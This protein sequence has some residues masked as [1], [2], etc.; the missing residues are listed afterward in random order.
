[1]SQ[2]RIYDRFVP[3]EE[4][5]TSGN[6]VSQMSMN[7]Q[8]LRYHRPFIA[9]GGPNDG[10]AVVV[11]NELGRDGRPKWT[12]EKG[13]KKPILRQ[14]RVADLFL[15][16]DRNVPMWALNA[17]SFRRDD[18]IEVDKEVQTSY[19]QRLKL[20]QILQQ[21]VSVGGFN[22]W[23][24]MSY[25]YDAMSDAHEAIVDMDGLSDGRSDSP[26]FIPRSVPLPFTHS[27][28]WYSDRVLAASRANGGQGL[29]LYSS[30][31]AARRVAEK[32]EDTAIGITTGLTWGTRANYFPHDLT[33]TVFG[34]TNYTNRNVKTNFTTPTSTN[35]PTSYNEFLAAFNTLY[36]DY[37]Y[38]PFAIFH[39]TDWSTYMNSPFST[40]GG[41]HPSETLRTMLLKHPDVSSIERLDRLTS[42]F[43]VLI[44][45][46]DKK[47]IRFINGMD[48]TTWQW[49]DLG[50]LRKNFKVGA[51]QATLPLSD[52]SG[53]CGYLHG[54]TA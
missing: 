14:Q 41:N 1:M 52:Y 12:M 19:R 28:F 21:K 17:T 6:V 5:N 31:Q 45:S 7:Q 15:N 44:V 4:S 20:V 29:D 43:T 23:G 24:K 40:S 37:V 33:S 16:G 2:A 9:E 34:L 13:E 30:E 10:K 27:D 46:L 51:V 26:M 39:S 32:I 54:T 42:T 49:D 25:E 3:A 8:Y 18:W 36:D 11:V 35:G 50:G 48:V 22:G 38:G 47:Y 53:R